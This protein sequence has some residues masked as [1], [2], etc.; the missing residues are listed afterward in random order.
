MQSMICEERGA[1]RRSGS[2]LLF[3]ERF[4]YNVNSLPVGLFL[5]H[6]S[7]V[8]RLVVDPSCRAVWERLEESELFV[9]SLRAKT[10]SVKT[11]RLGKMERSRERTQQ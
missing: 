4:T 10:A 2:V 6:S 7:E 5:D 11:R 3:A 1:S 9:G 8:L